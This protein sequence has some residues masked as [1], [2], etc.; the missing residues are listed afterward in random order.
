MNF[1]N[2]NRLRPGR[3]IVFLLGFLGVVMLA[4]AWAQEP[5]MTVQFETAIIQVPDNRQRLRK[6]YITVFLELSDPRQ[7]G[8]ACGRYRQVN[9]IASLVSLKYQ[10]KR[11]L[12]PV[13][14]IRTE[15][16]QRIKER[17]PDIKFEDLFVIE[18][19]RAFG[20]GAP[21]MDM[22]GTN[23][24]C[25]SLYRTPLD[26]LARDR[27][28]V[29]N[30]SAFDASAMLD[31]AFP[32]RLAAVGSGT[33]PREEPISLLYILLAGAGG[34]SILALIGVAVWR[35]QVRRKKEAARRRKIDATRKAEAPLSQRT[36]KAAPTPS[37]QTAKAKA[38]AAKGGNAKRK[39]D[40]L[41]PLEDRPLQGQSWGT[42]DPVYPK[43]G[44]RRRRKTDA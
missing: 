33:S 6:A 19:Q 44:D 29:A 43:R 9:E 41:K 28:V 39:Q 30:A 5:H 4:P 17:F 32:L 42:K 21:I 12:M 23:A 13:A 7:I 8:L 11:S 35:R 38:S 25:Y 37:Q 1:W 40:D 24:H 2:C 34:I 31:G 22:P 27:P 10:M 15:I 16:K 26:V 18:G 20:E 3:G 14:K 36:P